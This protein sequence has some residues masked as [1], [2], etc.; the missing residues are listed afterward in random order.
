MNNTRSHVTEVIK[1]PPV[2]QI[3]WNAARKG[4]RSYSFSDA[5][6]VAECTASAVVRDSSTFDKRLRLRHRFK[7]RAVEQVWG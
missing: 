1:L 7:D 6:L 4:M 3:S 5:R 2:S